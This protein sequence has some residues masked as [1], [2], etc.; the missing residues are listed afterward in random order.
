MPA[1]IAGSTDIPERWQSGRMY[2]TRNQA[3]VRTYRGFES[4]PL[5]QNNDISSAPPGRFQGPLMRG[6]FVRVDMMKGGM[7]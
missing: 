3:Y 7:P 5:L 1:R 6:F 4:L 2:L